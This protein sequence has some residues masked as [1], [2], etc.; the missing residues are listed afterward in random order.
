MIG[1]KDGAGGTWD[2]DF[3]DGYGA[4]LNEVFQ[5]DLNQS[6]SIGGYVSVGLDLFGAKNSGGTTFDEW[7]I[8]P[9]TV[10]A[11]ARAY[12]GSGWVAEAYLG[13]GFV[14]YPHVDATSGGVSTP[15]FDSSIAFAFEAGG[16]LGYRFTQ[17]FGVFVGVGY[18]HWNAPD[19]NQTTFPGGKAKPVENTTV[20]VGLF[21]KF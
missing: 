11:A 6:W 9:F 4:R 16:R 15:V 5:Y 1:G 17:M 13:I 7:L 3:R 10:G 12:F 20:D 14:A 18:E 21:L 2:D 19:V 8:F